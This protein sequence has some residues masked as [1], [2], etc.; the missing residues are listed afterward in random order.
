MW[1]NDSTTLLYKGTTHKSLP[2]VPMPHTGQPMSGQCWVNV[3]IDTDTTVDRRHAGRLSRYIWRCSALAV[4]RTPMGLVVKQTIPFR[5][6]V[7]IIC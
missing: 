3:R 7:L 5:L 6:L 2:C 1:Y 4:H